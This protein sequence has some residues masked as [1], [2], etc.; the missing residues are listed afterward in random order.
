MEGWRRSCST[1]RT[2]S[3]RSTTGMVAEFHTVLDGTA[4]APMRARPRRRP[5]LLGRPR[6]VHRRAADRGRG[7]DPR[8][9]VQPAHR[10]PRRA[11]GADHRRRARSVPRR[12][13][14]DRHGVRPGVLR[15]EDED[16]LTVRQHRRGARLR[17]PRRAR[18]SCRPAPRPRADLHRA[19]DR[20]Q[21]GGGDGSRERRRARRRAAR[22]RARASPGPSPPDRPARS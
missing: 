2:S 21:R 19:P 15:G 7:G 5:R 10:P 18:R 6:P 16:R 12:G 14:R 17:R 4:D 1:D 20:R 22:A 9:R 11:A 8:R 3:T 13:L